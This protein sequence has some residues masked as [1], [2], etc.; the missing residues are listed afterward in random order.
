M[1]IC[2]PGAALRLLLLLPGVSL[3]VNAEPVTHEI[4]QDTLMQVYS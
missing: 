3:R 4:I 2:R 1:A